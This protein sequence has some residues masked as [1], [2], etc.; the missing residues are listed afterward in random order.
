MNVQRSVIRQL[1]KSQRVLKVKRDKRWSKT[2]GRD[3]MASKKFGSGSS[4]AQSRS[5][6]ESQ[7]M[8]RSEADQGQQQNLSSLLGGAE[9]KDENQF[10]GI[11]NETH[12]K[13]QAYLSKILT[14]R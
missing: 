7:S 9:E 12:A 8:S 4:S 13:D 11:E 10:L 3:V 2:L 14:R 1:Q 6:T 5:Q